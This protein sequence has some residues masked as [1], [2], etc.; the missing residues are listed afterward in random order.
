MKNGLYPPIYRDREPKI[1]SRRSPPRSP[2]FGLFF[3]E[4]TRTSQQGSGSVPTRGVGSVPT[5]NNALEDVLNSLFLLV[6]WLAS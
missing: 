5:R 3:Q 6:L 2:C 1:S 4:N